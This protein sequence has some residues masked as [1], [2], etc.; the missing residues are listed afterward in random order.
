MSIKV[1]ERLKQVGVDIQPLTHEDKLAI[2][3]K[4]EEKTNKNCDEGVEDLSDE[5][6]LEIANWII[7][8][9]KKKKK[10]KIYA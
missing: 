1:H 9:K 2:D 8:K 3:K 6:I 10:I 4:I 5:E 7:R